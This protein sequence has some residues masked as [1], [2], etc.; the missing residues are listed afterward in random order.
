MQTYNSTV[1]PVTVRAVPKNVLNINKLRGR[2]SH[3]FQGSNCLKG[4]H[5]RT[6][7]INACVFMNSAFVP[8]HVIVE[9]EEV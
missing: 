5:I 1:L 2:Q 8:D 3:V 9:S 7:K 6:F 4:L